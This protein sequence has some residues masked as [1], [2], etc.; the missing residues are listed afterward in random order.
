M[1]EVLEIEQIQLENQLRYYHTCTY[2]GI[3][4]VYRYLIIVLKYVALNLSWYLRL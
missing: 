3:I 1:T 2:M 4:K